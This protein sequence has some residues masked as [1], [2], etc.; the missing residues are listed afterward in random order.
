MYSGE[1]MKVI[2]F[3][4][5]M[6]V[7]LIAGVLFNN[8]YAEGPPGV[9]GEGGVVETTEE[10]FDPTPYKDDRQP[11]GLDLFKLD[12]KVEML[13]KGGVPNHPTYTVQLHMTEKEMISTFVKQ[14][15]EKMALLK[16]AKGSEKEKRNLRKK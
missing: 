10:K 16:D 1:I 3:F 6:I 11:W 13:R 15:A 5:F 7:I 14:K 8:S 4:L 12:K 2:K 9:T